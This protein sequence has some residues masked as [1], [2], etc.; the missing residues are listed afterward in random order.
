MMLTL[1]LTIRRWRGAATAVGIGALLFAC[2]SGTL[3][4]PVAPASAQTAATVPCSPIRL[5]LSNPLPGD[6][7][8]PGSLVINGQAIDTSASSAPGIDRIQIFFDRARD[9][10]GRLIGEVTSGNTRPEQ[11][12]DADA[13]SVV[14]SIPQ[15]SDD[16]NTHLLY[17]YARSA[18]SGLEQSVAVTVQLTKPL[19][20]GPFTRL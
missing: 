1:E 13:F 3:S 7:L 11:R 6:L 19:N 9:N 14:A 4:A 15:S 8:F 17:A 20:V 18:Q 16:H 10:G 12:L 2:L 5:T